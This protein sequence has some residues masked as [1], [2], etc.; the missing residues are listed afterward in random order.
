M[1]DIHS[2]LPI[3]PLSTGPDRQLVFDIASEQGGY[4]TAAQA[5]AA[6]YSWALLSHHAQSGRFI[7]LRRGLYRLR[8]YPSFPREDVIA[9]WL[10]VGK[11]IAVVS[12][13]S[14]LDLHDLSDVIPDA[15]HLTIPRSRR[16]RP[17]THGVTIHSTTIPPGPTE[18]IVRNGVPVTTAGRSILDAAD[19]GTAPE[20]IE[21]AVRQAIERGIATADELR[22]GARSRG[23]RVA[24]LIDG[25]ME[26]PTS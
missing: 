17:T 20:Q 6:G 9:A 4:F 16:G 18:R 7:R 3:S 24:D 19:S 14:A 12:H 1:S 13:E 15:V 8:E 22:R 11:D 5:R 23:K 26:P 21:M 25:A 10:A 2:V